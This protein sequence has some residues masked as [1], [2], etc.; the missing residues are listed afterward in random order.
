VSPIKA[1]VAWG[2]DVGDEVTW[3]MRLDVASICT[4]SSGP[5][6]TTLHTFNQTHHLQAH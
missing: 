4:V 3:H 6:G 5:R 2:L 1:A